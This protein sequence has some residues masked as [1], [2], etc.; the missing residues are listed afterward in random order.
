MELLWP[1]IGLLTVHVGMLLWLVLNLLRTNG[2]LLDA[3]EYYATHRDDH[4]HGEQRHPEPS[5]KTVG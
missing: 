4:E 5:I 3:V 2:R 1:F